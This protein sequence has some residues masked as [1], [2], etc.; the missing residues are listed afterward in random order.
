[1]YLRE[2]HLL[3]ERVG[4]PSAYPFNIPAIR[5]LDKLSFRSNVTFF[6]GENGS[7]KSTLLEAIAYQ[8]GFHTGGGGRNNAYELASSESHL[9]EAIRLSWLPKTSQGF[10][11]RAESFYSFASH[12]DEIARED[13]DVYRAYGG[14]SLHERSHGESFLALFENRFNRPGLYLLDEPEA[15]LSPAR[16]LIF[17]RHI[18]EL[19]RKSQLIVATHSPIL[20]GYPHA[21]IYHFHESGIKPIRYEDTETYQITRRFLENR[22]FYLNELLEEEPEF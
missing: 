1:M 4:R 17:L 7:G 9:G 3:S 15:A 8:S 16:Q 14:R 6:T 13:P 5:G 12:V 10:F 22:A 11:L 2:L 18:H 20:L 19:Q 21:E